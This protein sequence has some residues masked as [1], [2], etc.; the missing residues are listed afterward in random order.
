M[1]I[2]T[3]SDFTYPCTSAAWA[4][5]GKQIVIGSQ[6]KKYGLCIWD[7]NGNIQ[8]KWPEDDLRVHDVAISPD[9]QRLVALLEKRIIV[10]DFTT[11]EKLCESLLDDKVNLNSV[12]ISQDSQYMLVSMNGSKIKLIEI[13]T[14]EVMETYQGHLQREFVI[15]STF[16][17]ANENFVVSGSEG[18][19]TYI[20]LS[21]DRPGL[22]Y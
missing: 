2:T 13:D 9:G 4:P 11:Y 7:I 12:N 3:I 20:H 5:D 14:G 8:H 22:D 10:Y 17:G 6:D 19:L 16:G 15:R 1:S 18:E 21:V